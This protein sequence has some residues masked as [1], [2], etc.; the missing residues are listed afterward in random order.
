MRTFIRILVVSLTAISLAGLPSAGA[1][2][3]PMPDEG[4]AV[5]FPTRSNRE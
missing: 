3:A 5:P 4:Q 2:S 1:V